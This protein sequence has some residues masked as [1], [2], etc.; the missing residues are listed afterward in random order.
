ME[1]N[2][3]IAGK[4]APDVLEFADALMQTGFKIAVTGEPDP[5]QETQTALIKWNKAS[6][7][8]ARS[9]VIQAETA[10]KNTANT[11][12]YFDAPH[13]ALLY[14]ELSASA[15]SKVLEELT[16]GFQY[17]AIETLNRI[18][19][20][21]KAAR[22]VFIVRNGLL[23]KDAVFSS[24]KDDFALTASPLVAAAEAAFTA[25]AENTAALV[26]Q[27]G[28]AQVLLVGVERQNAAMTADSSLALWLSEYLNALDS[29]KSRQNAKSSCTW[30]KAG[31]KMPGTFSLFR[32]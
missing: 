10:L 20:H 1:K 26:A 25:F 24:I 4:D 15:C 7:I 11:I 31:A 21:K 5:A 9:L 12:F 6:A 16:A 30:I 3:L 19:Q 2:A 14:P 28:A 23:P 8:S 17:L 27:K 32:L 13:F 22:L 18:E 29:A